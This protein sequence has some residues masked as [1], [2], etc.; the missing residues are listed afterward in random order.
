MRE[1]FPVRRFS[2]R[3]FSGTSYAMPLFCAF[4]PPL[5]E[6]ANMIGGKTPGIAKR[7]IIGL[8]P[9]SRRGTISCERSRL[10]G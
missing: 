3:A 1:R 5:S 2:S 7:R 9:S 6:A 10:S 4:F 8:N